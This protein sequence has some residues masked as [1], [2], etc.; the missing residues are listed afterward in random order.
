MN[1]I[2]GR[3]IGGILLGVMMVILASG[4]VGAVYACPDYGWHNPPPGEIYCNPNPPAQMDL[5]IR[6]QDEG[7]RDGVQATWTARNMAPGDEF[8]F[9]GHFI[10]LR[11]N[12]PEIEIGCNYIVS[13]E[14]S[15]VEGDADPHTDL[16]PDKMAKYM[17]I[18]MCIYRDSR[19][20]IDCLTGKYTGLRVRNNEWRINDVDGD[21]R[22]T[23]YD[24]K[25][26][27]LVNLPRPDGS[28]G[29]RFE[30]SV[31][32]DSSAGNQFQ[33]DTFDLTMFYRAK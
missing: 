31:K 27:P 23:F 33:G 9:E 5:K 19:W 12:V 10:G 1:L 21:N 7:W 13:E 3:K 26:D 14:F 24:L 22:L 28:N 6:D 29:S 4:I 25:K 30:M 18:T 15:G 16:H 2:A 17:V 32:F 8:A 20:L 11:G